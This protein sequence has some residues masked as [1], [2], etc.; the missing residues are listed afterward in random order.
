MYKPDLVFS[1]NA[2]RYLSHVRSDTESSNILLSMY[3]DQ[4]Y[5]PSAIFI[6][7]F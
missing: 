4:S 2:E 1:G 6:T 3:G 7:T 5:K